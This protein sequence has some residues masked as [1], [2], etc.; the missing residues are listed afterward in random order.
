MKELT[1]EKFLIACE[2]IAHRIKNKGYQELY[3]L[4]RGGLIPAV[5]VSHIT[6]IP[7]TMQIEQDNILVIDDIV[8]SGKTMK[9]YNRFD[10]A[11][12]Y[13]HKKSV[14]EPDIW[15]YEKKDDWILFPWETKESTKGN[16]EKE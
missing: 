13:Y 12:I 16:S 11:S 2:K 6:G 7:I 10:T 5:Y 9:D 4:P 8:D 15:I 14:F 1:Y 3:G